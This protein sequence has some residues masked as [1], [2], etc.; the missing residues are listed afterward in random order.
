MRGG[1][2]EESSGG[3]SL[4]ERRKALLQRVTGDLAAGK[5][6]AADAVG[7]GAAAA[8]AAAVAAGAVGSEEGAEDSGGAGGAKAEPE[9]ESWLDEYE[10][11][12]AA[13]DELKPGD[14]AMQHMRNWGWTGV[15]PFQLCLSVF[16]P[17][18]L[19]SLVSFSS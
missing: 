4:L 9:G 10:G 19:V 5:Q 8:A 18:T 15:P 12:P 7:A 6:G 3:R 11:L 2:E 13:L 17:T 14:F 1:A 16:G